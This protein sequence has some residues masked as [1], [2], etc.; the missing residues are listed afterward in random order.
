MATS[1]EMAGSAGLIGGMACN[2]EMLQER[3]SPVLVGQ[4]NAVKDTSLYASALDCGS[5]ATSQ[6]RLERSIPRSLSVMVSL[7]S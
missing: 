6:A 1:V 3:V 7:R 4:A 2:L 5:K